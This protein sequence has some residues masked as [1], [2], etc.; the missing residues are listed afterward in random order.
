[1]AM[2]FGVWGLCHGSLRSESRLAG[3]LPL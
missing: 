3:G 2:E 1:V